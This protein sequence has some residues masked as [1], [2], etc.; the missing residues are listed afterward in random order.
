MSLRRFHMISTSLRFD[1]RLTR[2][3]RHRE[4]KLAALWTIWDI[5]YGHTASHS[6]S[7]PV[8][9]S[10][11]MATSYA[12]R[13]QVY[14]GKAA[15]GVAVVGQGKRVVLEMTEGLKGVTVTCDNFFTP[16][17]LAQE[18][19]ERKVALVGTIRANKPEIPPR[20]KEKKERA[21]YSSIFA[22]TPTTTAVSYTLRRGK[23]VILLSTKHWEPAV[24]QD[25]KQKPH[26]ITDYNCC[27][28]G[29]DNLDKVCD[30]IQNLLLL[31]SL[32]LFL[33]YLVLL[34]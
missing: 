4:D 20:L 15:D 10:A 18:R 3:L 32:I 27:E 12:W 8:L 9:M 11:W 22:F 25:E 19:L 31:N 16:Y 17:S 30:F 24:Y 23:N 6:S 29:V 5:Q 33:V 28:A 13:C 14:T 34:Q 1:D 2:P 21:L 7:N 26:V